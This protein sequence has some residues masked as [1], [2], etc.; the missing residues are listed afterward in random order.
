MKRLLFAIVVLVVL[1]SSNAFAQNTDK[2]DA[3][4]ISVTGEAQVN[5]VPDEIIVTIGVQACGDT[6]TQAR[7]NEAVIAQAV[8]AAAKSI[9]IEAKS[10]QS[11]ALEI[12]LV[13]PQNYD[14]RECYD[15]NETKKFGAR[16]MLT[17]T[18]KDVSNLTP[19]LT[20]TLEAGAIKVMGVEYRTSKLRQYRD[21]ARSL[22]IKAAREKAV[23]MAADLGQKV[24]KPHT[25]TESPNYGRD[26]FYYGLW[27]SRWYSGS[28]ANVSQNVMSNSDSGAASEDIA[29]GQIA[30]TARVNVSF[31]LL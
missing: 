25:I 28:M 5:V 10:I 3:R 15:S 16:Q 12:D 9:G 19:L 20:K 7:D 23:A 8:L 1:S 26:W 14:W 22:A 11:D 2:S 4:L 18:L 21:Q 30:V 24:G 31:D 6:A 29:L 13:K 27:W 17:F